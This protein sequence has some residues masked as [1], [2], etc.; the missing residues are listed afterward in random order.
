MFRAGGTSASALPSEGIHALAHYAFCQKQD[1]T[2]AAENNFPPPVFALRLKVGT[3]EISY[4]MGVQD[5]IAAYREGITH[6]R[7][8]PRVTSG[9]WLALF[10]LA[11][12]I[13]IFYY[14]YAHAWQ[15]QHSFPWHYIHIM[16]FAFTAGPLGFVFLLWSMSSR[17]VVLEDAYVIVQ[18]KYGGIACS[19]Y[20][21]KVLYS[22]Q[23]ITNVF[24][25]LEHIT[26][27]S[28]NNIALVVP[29]RA[30]PNEQAATAFFGMALDF[31]P[32]ARGTLPLPVPETTGVWPP[33]PR[34]GA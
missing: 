34:P 28:E 31:W 24:Q 21:G 29:R 32:E 8:F 20:G 18:F 19:Q 14:G 10:C 4:T 6:F 9:I 26:I 1:K 22:W 25:G 15:R 30:F 11:L 23:R 17:R 16:L 2:Q 3:L 12:A 13:A 5:W 27:C 7:R 33:A